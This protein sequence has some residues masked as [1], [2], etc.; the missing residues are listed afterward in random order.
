MSDELKRKI[1]P[2][3]EAQVALE[4]YDDDIK[5]G[6]TGAAQ[7]WKGQAD[8]YAS[9]CLGE[10]P[11]DH[12][13]LLHFGIEEVGSPG[14]VLDEAKAKATPCSCFSYKGD[15]CWAKGIIGMLTPEQQETYCVAGKAY[16]AQPK[17][18]ERYSKFAAAAERAHREIEAM[19]KGG[20]RLETWLG[21]PWE[22]N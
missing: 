8:A 2:C 12:E 4:R 7:Y 16:K 19:P 22:E 14:I 17:L 15:K 13:L 21:A 1:N 10:M 18:T 3:A 6:H 11:S 20:E 9:Q 5:A